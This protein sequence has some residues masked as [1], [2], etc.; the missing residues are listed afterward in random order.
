MHHTRPTLPGTLREPAEPQT[1]TME[2][3]LKSVA[4]RATDAQLK[5][6]HRPSPPPPSRPNPPASLASRSQDQRPRK[7]ALAR[8]HKAA[9]EASIPK[10]EHARPKSLPKSLPKMEPKPKAA[11]STGPV[12]PQ[13]RTSR[14]APPTGL[15]RAFDAYCTRSIQNGALTPDQAEALQVR[16]NSG[17]SGMQMLLEE[18][19]RG[20]EVEVRRAGSEPTHLNPQALHHALVLL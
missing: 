7:S 3:F 13:P 18:G 11:P 1:C 4:H 20:A 19:L 8:L 10:Q 12:Q 15:Q 9:A 16:A 5:P 17:G 2:T 6:P 14:S